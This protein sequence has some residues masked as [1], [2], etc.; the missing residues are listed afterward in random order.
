MNIKDLL[1]NEIIII[2][3]TEFLTILEIQNLIISLR[4]NVK[5]NLYFMNECLSILMDKEYTGEEEGED[6]KENSG[7]KDKVER[8]EEE[9]P[10]SSA[11]ARSNLSANQNDRRSPFEENETRE[12]NPNW[13]RTTVQNEPYPNGEVIDLVTYQEAHA[14]N[15]EHPPNE[16]ATKR[17]TKSKQSSYKNFYQKNIKK[18]GSMR[19]IRECLKIDFYSK[20][21]RP[22]HNRNSQ[23][24]GNRWFRKIW[25]YTHLY[26]EIIDLKKKFKNGFLK[27]N[28]NEMVPKNRIKRFDLFQLF[29]INGKFYSIFDAPWVSVYFQFCLNAICIF[30]QQKVDR[31][32]LCVFAEKINLTVSNKLL[33]N[34]FN[35]IIKSGE[36]NVHVN[37]EDNSGQA[38][39]DHAPEGGDGELGEPPQKRKKISVDSTE[40]CYELDCA[41]LKGQHSG[42]DCDNDVRKEDNAN[43]C[44]WRRSV[45]TLP[46]GG[47]S[48]SISMKDVKGSFMGSHH[49]SSSPRGANDSFSMGDTE[50]SLAMRDMDDRLSLRDT[51]DSTSWGGGSTFGGISWQGTNDDAPLNSK[52]PQSRSK[53]QPNEELVQIREEFL[54]VRKTHIFCDDCSR[55]LEYR[56]NI[57]S[58][59]EALKK[60]Y[61]LLKKLKIMTKTFKIPKHLFCMC[62][63]FFFKDKYILYFKKVSNN[64][65][66]LR[67]I[68]KKKLINNFI[69]TFSLNFYKFVIRALLTCDDK[70]IYHSEDIFLFGFYVKYRNLLNMFNSPRIIYVYYSFHVILEKIKKLQLLFTHKHFL[71]LTHDLHFDVVAIIEKL[72]RS[73]AKRIYRGISKYIYDHVNEDMLSTTS[74]EELYVYFFQCVK[75]YRFV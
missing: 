50:S 11:I 52:P 15:L 64:L 22:L 48:D 73:D 20:G 43:A 57:K 36:R 17:K 30:C 14:N 33:L 39:T 13:S 34:Y 37:K 31:N 4:I 45:D 5:T 75:N 25:L 27:I 54:A 38:I 70:K 72:K 74:Y 60:D 51:N 6:A 2:K 47:K 12:R 7:V 68:L 41:S 16:E 23:K 18:V 69:F 19:S 71:K 24:E 10:P 58:I 1:H 61:E 32:S 63:Y 44:W 66:S 9:P 62:N 42:D 26:H 65:Q 46:L 55:I 21:K 67:K 59:F 28:N 35:H 3:I 8:N 40:D 53:N 56:M 29:K 49:D